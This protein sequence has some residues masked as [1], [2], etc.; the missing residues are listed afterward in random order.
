M[1][2]DL[3]LAQAEQT[4]EEGWIIWL[5]LNPLSKSSP[6]SGVGRRDCS[7]ILCF[8]SHFPSFDLLCCLNEHDD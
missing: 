3:L 4:E 1:L 7:S 5:P 2:V 8:Y 6:P